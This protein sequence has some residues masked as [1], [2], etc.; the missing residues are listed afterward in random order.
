MTQIPTH[1]HAIQ[2][3]GVDEIVHNTNKPVD[4]VG[5]HQL[6]LQVEACGI[7]FSDTKLLHAFDSHP[8]KSEVVEGIS[9][10]A[11]AEIPSY[12]PGMLPT[13]PG[14]E[15]VGRI[16][17]VGAEVTHFAVGDRVLVQADWKHLRTANSNGA[18]GYNFEGALQEYVVIDERCAVSPS[19]EEFLIHV[20]DG[21][22]AA[23]VGLIEPWATVE[24]SYAWA[25]RNHVAD[26]GRL[27][28][29]ADGPVTGID[30]LTAEHQPAEIVTLRSGEIADLAGE[31]FDDIVYYGADAATIETLAAMLGTRGVF[32]VVLGGHT[33]PR[34]VSLDIGRV[35]YDFIRFVGTPGD[36]PADGYA[37]IPPHG[38]LRA[39]D[40]VAII[41]AAG[42]MGMMHTI[43]A[44]T[45]G[46]E[47]ITVTGT[48]LSTDRLEHLAA[49][50]DPV[51]AERGV[52]ITYVNTGEEQLRYGFTHIS[53][54]VPV[55]ALVSQAVDLAAEDSILNAF[56]GIP[57]GTK[58]EFDLQGI[59]TRRVFMLGTSGS[60]VSD[61]RTVLRKIEEGIIDTHISL[62]AVTGMAG[63]TDAIGSVMNRTSG[64]KIMV[65][66]MLHDLPLTRLV[67]MAEKLPHVA[68][69][70]KDGIWTKEAEQALL[71][72]R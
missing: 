19:G 22:S 37:W 51:A 44:V 63:F 36:N 9:A 39:G 49:T 70:L 31:S 24:G 66:P 4:A 65:F 12:K 67:D 69:K 14:H 64:G 47:G 20:T 52:P 26:G 28:V 11:L 56:A 25:E 1:Q 33:I 7:C 71:A 13:V 17:E 48:D 40:K 58:G 62:D 30:A 72:G 54:M 2:F 34:K 59:I 10:E 29:V 42:P 23:A 38:E 21:P 27:L 32:C 55:P 5:P 57:A 15:P 60:D 43:R 61:M 41:G 18:F 6:L 68:A 46:F 16:V 53:C 50:V 8:R 3:V 45:S 35:H